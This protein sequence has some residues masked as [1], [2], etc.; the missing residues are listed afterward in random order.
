MITMLIISVGITSLVGTLSAID[1]IKYGISNNFT[2]MGANTF[3]IRNAS[4]RIHV[5]GNGSK[6]YRSI[7]FKEAL[8]FKQEFKFPV[9]TSISSVATGAARVKWNGRKTN[10]NIQVVGT[11]ENYI[12]TAG[13]E[14]QKGRN[15]TATEVAGASHVVIIGAD[16][17]KALFKPNEEA[18]DQTIRVGNALFRIIGVLKTKGNS[19]A[20]GGDKICL[21]PLHS[22]RQYFNAASPGNPRG[23]AIYRLN[24]MSLGMAT[25]DTYLE[26]ARGEFRKIRHL[27]VSAPDDFEIVKSDN[28]ATMMIDSLSN[29]TAG[30]TIIGLITLLGAAIGLMNIMFVSVTERTREIGIRKAIGATAAI[31]RNQFLIESV[32]I[33]ISGGIV[34]IVLGIVIGNLISMSFDSGFFI[35]W[36]WI[37]SGFIICIT[38]GLVSGYLPA[39]R[40]AQLDPIE[41]L[42]FE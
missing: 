40:A 21:L 25:P 15:L 28:I 18:L 12:L 2:R 1:A 4:S 7:S 5:G 23:G 36:F 35:P 27:P 9:I 41:S 33:C 6:N 42:R 13:Y 17:E 20:F 10:P 3:T 8:R 29:V 26:E 22:A 38:V 34:G 30:A 11:D 14:L 39:R 16:V 31:I 37:V 24:V 19:A 32:V